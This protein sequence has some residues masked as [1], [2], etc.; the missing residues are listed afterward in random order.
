MR[1]P[2]GW[3][4]VAAIPLLGHPAAIWELLHLHEPD[5]MASVG[6]RWATLIAI[7]TAWF[8]AGRNARREDQADRLRHQATRNKPRT[9]AEA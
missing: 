2:K 1:R 7:G 3:G 8:I 9:C 4:W 6:L 5:S